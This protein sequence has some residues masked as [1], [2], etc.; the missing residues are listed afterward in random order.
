[1]ML[2]IGCVEMKKDL[3]TQFINDWEAYCP[4]IVT[5]WNTEF[6]DIP[7]LCN[8]IKHVLGDEEL[9]RL[10]PWKSVQDGEIYKMGRKHQVYNIQ[11]IAHLDYFDLYRKFTYTAQESYRLDHIAKVELGESKL[12]IPLILLESGIQKTINRLL[13]TTYKT[14]R[15]L[16]V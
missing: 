13:N 6:F 4:D 5:G 2:N 7:Y 10:S 12:V 16:I 15:L 11:G 14:L 3:L 1:M 8:R 9:K